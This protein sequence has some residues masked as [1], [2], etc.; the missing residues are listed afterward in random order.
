MDPKVERLVNAC[1]KL[2]SDMLTLKKYCMEE[3]KKN[4][5]LREQLRQ[6]EAD[7]RRSE[8]EMDSISF[9]NKQ[10]EHRVAVL[11]EELSNNEKRKN[12]KDQKRQNETQRGIG[13]GN[14]A[15]VVTNKT[16][17][18]QD[19]L[20]FEELQKKIMDNA[21]LTSLIDDKDREL[22]LHIERVQNLEQTLQKRFNE[23][24]EMEQRLR[25]DVETLQSRNAEL[26]TKYIE[27]TS[28]LGSEDALSASGSDNT[29]LHSIDHNHISLPNV[30][31]AM[32][33]KEE[34][35]AFLEQEVAHW[36][37]QYEILKLSEA[38]GN[39]KAENVLKSTS[40]VLNDA[41]CSC[42]SAAAGITV[43][44]NVGESKSAQRGVR[45]FLKETQLPPAKEE[46]IYNN[47]SKKFE[48]LLKDKCIAESR[49]T[50]FE[51][52]VDHLQNCL[53]NATHE[54]TAKDEQMKSI[55]QALQ[56]LEED[57]ATTRLNYE[58]QISVLTEQVI[59]LSEQLAGCK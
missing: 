35:L 29:P 32:H 39:S 2:R 21:Q 5:V 48:D 42:S 33:T 51:T 16:D 12:D 43:R 18:A 31:A 49:I 11:Q 23:H 36:R 24:T 56:I 28:M 50:S 38:F 7:C 30:A 15:R 58:E 3:N 8:Q 47:F 52:E 10:L 34:R 9:R 1:R 53:E 22:K 27:A 57:L 13:G 14:G 26:E 37:A 19:E 4:A 17:R 41:N 6:R 54:L 45:D 46:L 59:S 20:I 55:S 25:Q 40:V 44:T